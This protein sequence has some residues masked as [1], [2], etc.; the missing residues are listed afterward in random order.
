MDNSAIS[1]CPCL[2]CRS[3]EERSLNMEYPNTYSSALPF[4][5]PIHLCCFLRITIYHWI[6]II[7]QSQL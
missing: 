3:L 2:V 7:R 4:Y 1:H 6:T 5:V